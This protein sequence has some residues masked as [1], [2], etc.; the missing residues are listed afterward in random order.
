MSLGVTFSGLLQEALGEYE[1]K[2]MLEKDDLIIA[3]TDITRNG[4]VVGYPVLDTLD[5]IGHCGSTGSAAFYV[6]DMGLYI[7]GS[8]NQQARTNIAFQTV[9]KIFNKLR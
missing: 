1:N 4:D 2:F 7:T 6:P 8:I 9:I 3:N 5:M